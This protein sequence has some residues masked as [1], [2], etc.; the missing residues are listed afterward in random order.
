MEYFF[1][2][3]FGA[4]KATRRI[5]W[6]K[7]PNF[8]RYHPIDKWHPHDLIFGI[9][10]SSCASGQLLSEISRRMGDVY[11]FGPRRHDFTHPEMENIILTEINNSLIRKIAK[12][13]SLHLLRYLQVNDTKWNLI[14]FSICKIPSFVVPSIE[15]GSSRELLIFILRNWRIMIRR[16]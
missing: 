3:T 12:Y 1:S 6:N 16:R 10:K 11:R 13:T 4:D 15:L 14:L 9:G 7:I 5:A 2:I 8:P